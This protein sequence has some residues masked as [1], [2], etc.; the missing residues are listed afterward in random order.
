M[1][2]KE[3]VEEII[4]REAEMFQST[5]NI[6]GRASCQDDLKTFYNMRRSQMDAWNEETLE[7]YLADLQ[8]V[9]EAGRNLVTEKYFHMM[10]YTHPMEYA[11]Q[12]HMVAMPEE[13]TK[14]IAQE[15]CD[16]M[17]ADTEILHKNYPCVAGAGRPLHSTQDALG[18]VSV[19]TYQKGELYTYS[20][21]TLQCLQA[22]LKKLQEQGI[23][24]AAVILENG[25]K[26]YGYESLEQAETMMQAR[27]K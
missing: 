4:R 23:S 16:V 11:M 15:I 2:K 3:L 5:Q 18:Y 25:V 27:K 14:R 1:T 13:E 9:Q 22:H 10:E 26:S 6:G 20:L 12:K 17:I 19:E 24:L 21:H 7:S 8:A